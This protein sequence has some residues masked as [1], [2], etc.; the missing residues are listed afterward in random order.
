MSKRPASSTPPRPGATLVDQLF[1]RVGLSD[2][3]R[4][5]RAMHAWHR[6]AGARLGKHTRPE[7]VRGRSLFVRVASAPWANELSYIRASLLER[8]QA[9]RG[10]EWIDDLRFTIG[11]LAGLPD[12]TDPAS[13]ASSEPAVPPRPPIDDGA[14][15]GELLKVHDP[16]LRGAL[17]ELFAHAQSTR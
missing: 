11:P 1:A 14:V 15:A 6:M 7:R 2:D 3:A 8:L 4:A 9:S 5:Y 12:F 10:A 13:A 17:A 16:E